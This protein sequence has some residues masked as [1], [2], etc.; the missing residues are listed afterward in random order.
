MAC[1]LAIFTVIFQSGWKNS[2]VFGNTTGVKKSREFFK[3]DRGHLR[4]KLDGERLREIGS[5]QPI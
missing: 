1:L 5:L 4:K 2:N 3:P